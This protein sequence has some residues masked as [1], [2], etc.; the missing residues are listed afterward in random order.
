MSAKV[1]SLVWS[2]YNPQR[3]GA[4]LITALALADEA[5]DDGGGIFQSVPTLA[6]KTRQSVRAVRMQLRRLEARKVLE[7]VQKSTGGVGRFSQYRV[8]LGTLLIPQNPAFSD[9]ETRHQMPGF[10]ALI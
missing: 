9:T 5:N 2:Y 6:E 7:C 4:P 1:T 10:W 3:C 8:D